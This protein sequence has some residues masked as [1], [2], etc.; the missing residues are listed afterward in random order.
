M[1]ALSKSQLAWITARAGVGRAGTMRA[2]VA[3]A[4]DQLEAD[5]S[6][7]IIHERDIPQDGDPDDTPQ[8]AVTG[9]QG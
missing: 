4:A 7:E 1:A 6:G 2:G 3:P 5:L 9:R 8:T